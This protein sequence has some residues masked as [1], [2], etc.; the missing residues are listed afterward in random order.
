[1]PAGSSMRLRRAPRGMSCPFALR[2][3][4]SGYTSLTLQELFAKTVSVTVDL[5]AAKCGCAASFRL[6]LIV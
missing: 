4:R 6:V 3:V 5:S 2:Y 1:M